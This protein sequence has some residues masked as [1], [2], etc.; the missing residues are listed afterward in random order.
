MDPRLTKTVTLLVALS[1]AGCAHSPTKDNWPV[2]PDELYSSF[3]PLKTC[4]GTGESQA[5]CIRPGRSDTRMTV[6]EAALEKRIEAVYQAGKSALQRDWGNGDL[7]TAGGLMAVLG[8]IADRAGL[9][10][11]GA[12]AGLL[13]GSGRARYQ[14]S[15]QTQAYEAAGSAL[16][17]IQTQVQLFDDKSRDYVLMAGESEE[18]AL[19]SRAPNLAINAVNKA[20]RRLV[21]QLQQLS[22]DPMQRET[23]D[24]LVKKVRVAEAAASAASATPPAVVARIS[25]IESP[26]PLSNEEQV[27]YSSLKQEDQKKA[28]EDRAL[29]M[30]AVQILLE[31]ERAKIEDARAVGRAFEADLAKCTAW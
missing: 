9:V 30:Q 25:G 21:Q 28:D 8:G 20:S 17:C 23:L 31:K 29:R 26:Q 1:A 6:I 3:N 2:A 19:A 18:R 5:G 16:S 7:V 22:A 4:K 27:K 13:G 11:T 10:N 12:A 24:A 15:A 14:Y